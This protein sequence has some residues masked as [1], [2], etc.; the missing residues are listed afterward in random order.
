MVR[1]CGGSNTLWRH[2]P[3]FTLTTPLH[4]PRSTFSR[5]HAA[6]S[7]G[8]VQAEAGVLV[9]ANQTKLVGNSAPQGQG[10]S[11]YARVDV[12]YLLPAPLAHYTIAQHG[13]ARLA[14]GLHIDEDYPYA[15]AAAGF[16]NLYSTSSDVASISSDLAS[17]IISA[18]V[19]QRCMATL[20]TNRFNLVRSA[21]V[22]VRRAISAA[23]RRSFR[24]RARRGPTVRRARPRRFLARPGGLGLRK[25]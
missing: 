4:Q 21:K 22:R 9:L 2:A 5:C 12:A 13:V 1:H 6:E 16:T 15:C 24:R 8:A 20:W 25:A 3:L 23:S 18:G 17:I 14:A 19:P 7:G 11:L 10:R